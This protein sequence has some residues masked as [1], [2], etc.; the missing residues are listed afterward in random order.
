MGSPSLIQQAHQRRKRITGVVGGALAVAILVVAVAY[1]RSPERRARPVAPPPP[2][3]T[4]VNRQLSGYTYTR[5]EEGRRIFSIHANRTVAFNQ[6]DS[7]V[8]EGV[9]VEVFGTSGARHDV[10]R[11]ERCDYNPDSQEFFA[12]GKVSIQLNDLASDASAAGLAS[13]WGGGRRPL[14]VFLETSK[15]SFKQEGSVAETTEPVKFRAANAS[16]TA[17]GLSYLPRTGALELEKDVVLN[18]QPRG[19]PT[20]QPPVTL[21]ASRLR[22][23]KDKNEATLSGPIEIIQGTRRVSAGAGTILLEGGHRVSQAWLEDGVHAVDKSEARSMDIG[24][25]RIQAEFDPSD[26]HLKNLH[27]EGHVEGETRSAGRVSHL[28]AESF[29][30]AF[31]GMHPQPVNGRVSGNANLKVETLSRACADTASPAKGTSLSS[32]REELAAS[33]ILFSFRP[34]KQTLQQAQTVGAG[35]LVLLSAPD[36]GEREVFADPLV[37]DFDAHGQLRELRGQSHAKVIAHPPKQAKPG[38]PDQVSTSDR[39]K[40]NFDPATG[41]LVSMEQVGDF[42]FTEGD[43]KASADQ[44]IYNSQSQVMTLTGHPSARDPNTQVRADRVAIDLQKDTVEGWGHVQSTQWDTASPPGGTKAPSKGPAI[45][46]NVVAERVIAH[47]D[48]QV[49][50][51]EG[52]VRAWHGQD[53]VESPFLDIYNGARRLT[54]SSGVL[55]SYI[56]AAS[57]ENPKG[58]ASAGMRSENRPV[59]IRADGVDYSDADRKGAYRGHVEL[60]TEN[61]TLRADRMDVYSSRGATAEASEVERAVAEGHVSVVEPAR[62]ATGDHA[63]YFAAQGKIVLTGGPPT[64]YDAANGFTSG[65]SLTLFLHDDTIFVDGGDQSPTISKRRISP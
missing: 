31:A 5:S 65:R 39:L 15:V 23:D 34:G 42:Q 36:A 57:T 47:R 9:Y 1:W 12:A 44:A 29:E 21:T 53:V 7:T 6:S 48:T 27:G 59:T 38:R 11:T 55:T 61:S 33:E 54:A 40:A 46:T 52:H 43:R 25:Q 13:P 58:A 14:P 51:Y 26:G 16:G 41:A 19:G 60:R 62:R 2:V 4:N 45:P 22:F 64:V 63:E 32:G 18:L 35:H 30:L 17:K 3:P 37:M 24:A 8:L 50:H 20:P 28:S 49:V 10:L 56:Q